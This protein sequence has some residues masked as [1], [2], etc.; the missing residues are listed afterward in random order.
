MFN[1][2]EEQR[3]WRDGDRIKGAIS[4]PFPIYS[5]IQREVFLK[6]CQGINCSSQPEELNLTHKRPSQ[7]CCKNVKTHSS[8]LFG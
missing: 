2:E 8:D 4:G 5:L 6:I 3:N 7:S 1:R